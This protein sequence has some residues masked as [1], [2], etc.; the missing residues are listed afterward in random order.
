MSNTPALTKTERYLLN[1][2][3]SCVDKTASLGALR[4]AGIHCA[5]L[6]STGFDR[7]LRRMV[8]N[9]LL[10]WTDDRDLTLTF[11]GLRALREARS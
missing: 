11:K 10:G 7:V 1:E 4:S 8:D 6:T 5:K 3:D 9:T 2:V